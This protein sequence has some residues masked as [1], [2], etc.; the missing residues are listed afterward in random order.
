MEHREV[1][2]VRFDGQH[3][4]AGIDM[5]KKSWK[6]SVYLGQAFHKR[7]AQ[8]PDPEVLANYLERNFPGAA[9]H[10]VYEAG[11]FGFWAHRALTRRSVHSMVI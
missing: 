6:I 2:K 1:T 8:P 3:V 5:G 9:Y 10:T 4:Y 11:C 7:F